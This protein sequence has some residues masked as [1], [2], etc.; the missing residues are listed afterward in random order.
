M[1]IRKLFITA[2][3]MGILTSVQ[4]Q[5][6][7]GGPGPAGPMHKPDPS[8]RRIVHPP[9]GARRMVIGGMPY[10]YHAGLYYKLGSDGYV[11]VSLPLVR[12]LPP[13][14][15]IILIGGVVYY[16]VGDIYYQSVPG[17]Y[18]IVDKPIVKVMEAPAP[19]PQ[20]ETF[21]LYVPK[22]NEEGFVPV[23]LKRLEG[24]FLGPQ[25]EFYPSA[26]QIEWLTEMYGIPQVL[27][28]VRSDTFFI[29]VPDKDGE[30]FTRV[31]LKRYK[32]GFR[33]PQ[34]EFYPLIP[35]VAQLTEMYGASQEVIETEEE[36]ITII[37]SKK[38]GDGSVEV[39]LTKHNDGYL[40]PQGEFY[41]EI[42]SKE[43]L[44]EIYGK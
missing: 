20:E 39:K 28:H 25:G 42:P 36:V 4:G 14:H 10:W 16:I 26:P 5:P 11:I 3:M 19:E 29:H 12:I 32:N 44:S 6:R 22:K 31:A 33:G 8:P 15:R 37:V 41:P 9:S 7:R 23:I 18:I 13:H 21:T 17:G 30:G 27:R 2:M 38:T 35:S 24:G 34:G 43:L 40:G 1:D